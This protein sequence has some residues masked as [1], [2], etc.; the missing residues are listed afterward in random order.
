[1]RYL[2]NCASSNSIFHCHNQPTYTVDSN[3]SLFIRKTLVLYGQIYYCYPTKVLTRL[4][5]YMTFNGCFRHFAQGLTVVRLSYTCEYYFV[6]ANG[7]TQP[8]NRGPIYTLLTKKSLTLKC[9]PWFSEKHEQSYLA[10]DVLT[11]KRI[12]STELDAPGPNHQSEA[13]EADI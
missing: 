9:N 1:M 11:F 7:P 3:Y 8:Q 2:T 5:P 6:R 13:L 10:S 12:V 4:T